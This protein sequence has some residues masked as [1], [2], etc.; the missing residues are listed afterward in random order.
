MAERE[1][2]RE[3]ERDPL[4]TLQMSSLPLPTYT[5]IFMHPHTL[6]HIFLLSLHSTG[7]SLTYLGF[8]LHGGCE[9]MKI[10]MERERQLE[11]EW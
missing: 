2:E 1:R 8:V 5:H 10:L 9:K 6:R 4:K 7:M 11:T 3:R